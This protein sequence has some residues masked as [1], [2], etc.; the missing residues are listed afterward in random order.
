M[1]DADTPVWRLMLKPMVVHLSALYF[2]CPVYL[3]GGAMTQDDPRDIDLALVLPDDL[4]VACYSDRR[5]AWDATKTAAAVDDWIAVHMGV[6]CSE[7]PR[8]WYRWAVDCAKHSRQL[9]LALHRRV[10]FKVQPETLAKIKET[11]PRE[12]IAQVIP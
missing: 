8:L 12:L 5:D 7:P 4:F 11:R 3:V 9:T 6:K 2:G 10:D 1:S